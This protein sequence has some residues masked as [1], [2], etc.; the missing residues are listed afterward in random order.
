MVPRF[1]IEDTISRRFSRFNAMSTQLVDRLLSPSD[2]AHPVSHF[3]ASWKDLF[4]HA[5]HNLNNI[6]MVG[7][8]IQKHVNQNDK[9]IR[10]SFRTSWRGSLYSPWSKVFQIK[11]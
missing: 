2:A 8:T 7:I 3:L 5:L 9:T 4:R 10:V 6:D 1:E 11:L